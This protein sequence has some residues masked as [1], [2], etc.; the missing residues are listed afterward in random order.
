[1]VIRVLFMG[2]PD[3]AV[4][5]V[6]AL[7]AHSGTE[8]CGVVTA[9]DRP[10]GR[11]RRVQPPPVKVWAL[12]ERRPVLQIPTL[13]RPEIVQA[14][15]AWSADVFIVTAFGLIL[16]ADV[17]Q[18]PRY[19]CLNVHF[20]LLPKYRGAAPVAHAILAGE[21]ETGVTIIR[22]TERVDAGPILAQRAVPIRP[23]DTAATLERRLAEI[24]ARLL[25]ETLEPYVRGQLTPVPQDETRATY[26]PKLTKDAGRIDWRQS[27]VQIERCI[28]AM[29]PW[30][31]A[32]TYWRGRLLKIWK[33]RVVDLPRTAS[34]GTT[35]YVNKRR[36]I[37]ACGEGGL[38]LLEVQP[39]GRSRMPV[40]AF[41]QGHTVRVGD[42]LH[43]HPEGDT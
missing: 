19:G 41:L 1:M 20:S 34:P 36:W 2:T 39:E 12:S 38:E 3:A 16:P 17:L 18:M 30:P 9:P 14:L 28:R 21:R 25:I 22:M 13:R 42:R 8:V 7:H 27:A 24:G 11:G 40:Q 10:R 23:D 43:A 37:V 4:T 32:F 35:V 15:Q 33:A 26:A 6:R 29:D 31:T 5:V